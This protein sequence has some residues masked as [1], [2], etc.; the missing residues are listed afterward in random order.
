[1]AV[2]IK[3]GNSADA[4]R[5]IACYVMAFQALECEEEG[6]IVLYI[7]DAADAE[8]CRD[9]EYNEVINIVEM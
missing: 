5:E 4:R 3:A 1:M 8:M 6:F 9:M 2:T 7:I